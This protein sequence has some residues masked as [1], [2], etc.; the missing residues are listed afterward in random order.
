MHTAVCYVLANAPAPAPL[1]P[2]RRPCRRR[3]GRGRSRALWGV[4]S[5][6]PLPM[7]LWCLVVVLAFS[8]VSGRPRVKAQARLP[9]RR[10]W[11]RGCIQYPQKLKVNLRP[12]MLACERHEEKPQKPHNYAQD[13]F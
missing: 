9:P 10:P 1:P 13:D 12:T 11:R 4:P 2:R 6:R 3:V 5:N 7:R 8:P